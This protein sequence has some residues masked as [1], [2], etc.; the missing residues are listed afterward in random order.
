MADRPLPLSIQTLAEIMAV[1]TWK[2]LQHYKRIAEQEVSPAVVAARF[3]NALQA[4]AEW[5]DTICLAQANLIGRECPTILTIYKTAAM[6][7]AARTLC[8]V[9]HI[10]SKEGLRICIRR[11]PMFIYDYINVIVQQDEVRSMDIFTQPSRK[12]ACVR[13]AVLIAL[14]K[15]TMLQQKSEVPPPWMSTASRLDV[16]VEAP[17]RRR[18]REEPPPPPPL[19]APP[20]PPSP[21]PPDDAVAVAEPVPFVPFSRETERVA[22]ERTS[23]ELVR[24]DALQPAPF[25]AAS[26]HSNLQVILPPDAAP[27]ASL[28]SG[29]S[30]AS[31]GSL[32]SGASRATDASMAATSGSSSLALPSSSMT[33][34][35]TMG[36]ASSVGFQSHM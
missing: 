9:E 22:M 31:L 36:D 10:G 34:P 2:K 35:D 3:G 7:H 8:G 25:D 21:L 18:R 30:V 4:V 27:A 15:N 13:T 6:F 16:P 29:G 17:R 5:D 19:P 20:A 33:V 23:P 11:F 1:Y 32:G 12:N 14:S 26:G 24:P 28:A